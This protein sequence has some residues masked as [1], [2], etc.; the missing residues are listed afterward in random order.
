ML[1]QSQYSK[2]KSTRCITN[3]IYREK[4]GEEINLKEGTKVTVRSFSGNRPPIQGKVVGKATS[5]AAEC[6]IIKCTD[7]QLPNKTYKYKYFMA[8]LFLIEVKE[9]KE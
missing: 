6:H 3:M 9:Q 8:P 5:G 1:I 7:K 2:L 4:V